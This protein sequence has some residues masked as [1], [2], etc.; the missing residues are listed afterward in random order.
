MTHFAYPLVGNEAQAAVQQRI[1]DRYREQIHIC[2]DPGN[3]KIESE[4]RMQELVDEY[5]PMFA[6]MAF[7][8]KIEDS[9]IDPDAIH[10][11]VADPKSHELVDAFEALHKLTRDLHLSLG[12]HPSHDHTKSFGKIV[13]KDTPRTHRIAFEFGHTRKAKVPVTPNPTDFVIQNYRAWVD[14]LP[15]HA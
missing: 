14:Q 15:R 13:I 7:E 3:F 4:E 2:I 10:V 1:F 6:E 11:E 9:G 8:Q 12:L 5:A